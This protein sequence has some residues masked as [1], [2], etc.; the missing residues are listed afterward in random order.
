MK[1]ITLSLLIVAIFS[2][3]SYA[4]EVFD[5]F[6]SEFSNSKIEKLF[7]PLSGY[8]EVMTGLNDFVYTGLVFPLARGYKSVV[9]ENIRLGISNFFDNLAFPINFIN[10][11]FQLKLGNAVGELV[12][13]SINSTFGL[14]GFFDPA[15]RNLNLQSHKEDFGQTLGYWGVGGGFHIVLPILGN[16]NL[17]DSLGLVVDKYIDP[18]SYWSDRNYNVFSDTM[19]S[20]SSTAFD[21]TNRS[22][23]EE[24]NYENLKKDAVELYP[25]F[26]ELYEQ[27]REKRIAE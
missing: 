20:I 6:E 15:H 22:S 17:R 16:S 1:K 11:T 5:D 27:N 4:E 12:R 19:S 13:F 24:Q 23:F 21:I 9:H 8:N 25:F 3:M 7:D 26:R 10:N 2:Y 14:L 18:M